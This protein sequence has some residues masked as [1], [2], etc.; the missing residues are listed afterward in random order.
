MNLKEALTKSL[1][2]ILN[3]YDLLGGIGVLDLSLS[4][5]ITDDDD[6]TKI[7]KLNVEI[8][9]MKDGSFE[10]EE[11]TISENI[12]DDLNKLQSSKSEE[13]I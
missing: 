1:E 6:I 2:V 7:S 13:L 9:E 5:T 4:N 10:L 3:N 8:I 12:Y 11:S